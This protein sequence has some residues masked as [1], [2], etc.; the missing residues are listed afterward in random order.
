MLE[1]L[2]SM[3]QNG[4]DQDLQDAISLSLATHQ[5]HYGAPPASKLAVSE[6]PEITI[7]QK[8]VE[9]ELTCGICVEAFRLGED[10]KQIPCKHWFHIDCIHP[11][12][13]LRNSCP[14]CRFELPTL[15]IDYDLKKWEEAQ[16][17]K[18]DKRGYS[19]SMMYM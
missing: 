18:K 13:K 7:T 1:M 4:G 19:E 9:R 16:E 6:L 2:L 12:L 14:T 11:W 3:N 10:A 15:N 8:E 17:K 5:T